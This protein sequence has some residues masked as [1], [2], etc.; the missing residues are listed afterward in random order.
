MTGGPKCLSLGAL[1]AA[2]SPASTQSPACCRVRVPTH[3]RA[4]SQLSSREEAGSAGLE[5][6]E[7]A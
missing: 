2:L 1:S 6:G 4:V 3:S 5:G 7:P